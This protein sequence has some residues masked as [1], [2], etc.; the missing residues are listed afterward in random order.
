MKK[1]VLTFTAICTFAITAAYAQERKPAAT[2]TGNRPS[3]QQV[4]QSGSNG[5]GEGV[6]HNMLNGTGDGLKN[7]DTRSYSQ[8]LQDKGLLPSKAATHANPHHDEAPATTPGNANGGHGG[9]PSEAEADV[10]PKH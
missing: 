9:A 10:T 1:L 5:T 8:Q 7:R 2:S 4:G 3:T 6:S